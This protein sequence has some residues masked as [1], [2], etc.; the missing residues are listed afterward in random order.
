MTAPVRR[1]V[2]ADPTLL[3]YSDRAGEH[4][5]RAVDAR[6][7]WLTVGLSTEPADRAT[8]E[9]ALAA[10]Y[11]RLSRRRP[12]FVWVDSPQQA[13]PL[14]AD[15]PTHDA[16]R[17]WVSADQP[18]GPPP[19]AS[20]LAARRHRLRT[21][22]ETGLTD[23]DLDPPSQARAKPT[24][25]RRPGREHRSAW[26]TLSPQAA[27]HGGVSLRELL[28][29]GV[30]EALHTSL[31]DGFYLP[32][33]TALSTR[34]P[35]PVAWYGQQDASWIAF[36][37][38]ARRLGLAHYRTDDAEQLDDWAA[39]ARSCGWWWPDERVCVVV[40]RPRVIESEPVPDHWYDQRRLRH[41]SRSPVVYR[42]G[43]RPP[44]A[45][46]STD[47]DG[48]CRATEIQLAPRPGRTS[49]AATASY[50]LG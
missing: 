22:L 38:V 34:G 6:R 24:A 8:A 48:E 16:L 23:P 14:V 31:A 35:L 30:R 17:A 11:A 29:H 41:G 26:L 21:A 25:G 7:E 1:S 3:R 50:S 49:G 20:D 37:D 47:G 43:W 39:L 12:R 44:V 45:G 33:R 4:W 5:L 40:E 13:L 19:L 28:R 27:L 10:I 36:Y 2:A 15:L 46:R 18:S 32:V 42:D 9:Q